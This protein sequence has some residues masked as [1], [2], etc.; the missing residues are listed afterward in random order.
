M[1]EILK[2]TRP[3]N[4]VIVEQRVADG[5][6]NGTAMCV[7]HGKDIANW[8]KTGET[9]ELVEALARRLGVKANSSKKTNSDK[10][11]VSAT[12][13]SLVIVKRGSP[14]NGGGTWIHHKLAVNLAQWCNTEF[15]LLVADWVEEWLITG[16]NPV[17][18]E[19]DID[20]EVAAWQHR[21][22]IRILLKDFL[23]PELMGVVIRYALD[24]GK[25]PIKLASSV[26]DL[27]NKRIQGATSKQIKVLGGLPISSLLRDYLGAKFLFDYASINKFAKNAIIDKGLHPLEAV[28][29][30]C[31]GCLGKSYIPTLAPIVG[32]LYTEG[33]EL[34]SRRQ[35]KR[36]AAGIQLDLL[37][38][39][40]AS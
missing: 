26:H 25:N 19:S 29:E 39:I 17:Q 22:D 11:R 34:K 32:N 12:Y 30:A 10:T 3:V 5:F 35:S 38:D 1:A 23:R 16:R 36:L 18:A 27:M 24:H 20:Q 15:A 28:N 9:F 13:P 14:E 33:R 21:Y 31:D 4:G 2:F 40:Q 37:N 7:A 6:I 8:L